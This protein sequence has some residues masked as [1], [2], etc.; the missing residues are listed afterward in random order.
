MSKKRTL[1]RITN[2]LGNYY[3]VA[4]DPTEA[5]QA[6]RKILDDE[7]YGSSD[8]RATNTITIMATEIVEAHKPF[9]L[10]GHYLLVK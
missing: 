9:H 6:L 7:N 4:N 2:K 3:V 5:D 8:E 1:Y 10:T